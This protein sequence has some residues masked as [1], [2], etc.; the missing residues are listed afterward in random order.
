MFISMDKV[1]LAGQKLG[2][3]F[4]SR[5]G[6]RERDRQRETKTEKYIYRI[7]RERVR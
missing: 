1:K 2:R 5:L 4:N 7:E 3:V 6:K